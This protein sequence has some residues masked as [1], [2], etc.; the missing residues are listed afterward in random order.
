VALYGKILGEGSDDLHVKFFKCKVTEIDG[1]FKEG[2][3]SVNKCKLVAI[4]DSSSSDKVAEIVAN[5]TAAA[6]P[7]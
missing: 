5:E 7:A 6:L 4:P 3:F 2:G 1:E